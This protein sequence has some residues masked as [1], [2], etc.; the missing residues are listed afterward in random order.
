MIS[1][2]LWFKEC[3]NYG[4]NILSLGNAKSRSIVPH[5]IEKAGK[6]SLTSYP[7][8]V[9]V[10]MAAAI[11]P[12]VMDIVLCMSGLSPLFLSL[13]RSDKDFA[14]RPAAGILVFQFMLMV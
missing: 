8:F 5:D 2:Y 3:R 7:L 12:L 1:Q 11:F 10:R 14:G 9:T 6:K 13:R 4:C